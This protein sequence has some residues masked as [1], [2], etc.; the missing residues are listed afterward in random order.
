MSW[1]AIAVPNSEM[2]AATASAGGM[3]VAIGGT[4]VA[5][6]VVLVGGAVV[7]AV[8]ATGGPVLGAVVAGDAGAV[9][10]G[11]VAVSVAT[12]AIGSPVSVDPPVRENAAPE[13]MRADPMPTRIVPT[14]FRSNLHPSS[15]AF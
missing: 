15:P 5:G 7:G 9:V 11:T 12:E 14:R 8:V 1:L 6:K 4:V 3:V 2:N 13:T 10:G